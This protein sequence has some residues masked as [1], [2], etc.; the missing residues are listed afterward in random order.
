[1]RSGYGNSSGYLSEPEQREY[2]NRS[3]TLNT[4]RRPK[5]N[6]IENSKISTVPKKFVVFF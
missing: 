5:N 6:E 1:M 4:R 2:T 3:A